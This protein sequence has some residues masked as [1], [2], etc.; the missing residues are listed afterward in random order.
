MFQPFKFLHPIIYGEYPKSIQR[1]VKDMLPKFTAE[2]AS[3][4]R[5]TIDYVGLNQYS[6]TLCIMFLIDNQML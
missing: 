1:T 6:S 5:G 3:V 2:E 4:V